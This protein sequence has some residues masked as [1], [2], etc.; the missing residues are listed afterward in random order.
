MPNSVTNEV[1]SGGASLN[2]S[3]GEFRIPSAIV[4]VM[5][6]ALGLLAIPPAQA[7]SFNC[8]QAV[9]PAERAICGNAN[10]SR[11]DEQA[12]GMYF[13]IVGSGASQQTLDQIKSMQRKF[14][15]A[16]NACGASNDCLVDAYTSQM[17]YL[18]NVKSN[19][20][21]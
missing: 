18:K 4:L 12:A 7:A 15:Q 11:L 3:L 17:M 9:L 14:V 5:S 2:T 21:L 1:I 6:C 19:L 8:Q 13:I 10:L 20:G 16:R